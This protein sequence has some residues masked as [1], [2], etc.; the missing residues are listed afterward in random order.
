M[1]LE[2]VFLWFKE[3]VS[4]QFNNK[5]STIICE[6]RPFHWYHFRP[7][8]VSLDSTF[9]LLSNFKVKFLLLSH[10]FLGKKFLYYRSLAWICLNF[11][12]NIFLRGFLKFSLKIQLT[13]NIS[14]S[15]INQWALIMVEVIIPQRRKY[16]QKVQVSYKLR[17]APIG[18]INKKH[19]WETAHAPCHL[20]VR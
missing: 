16:F 8:L 1:P 17:F 11:D 6:K 18:C 14:K 2:E 7:L 9:K 12:N 20:I 19:V 4:F 10:L 13:I 3:S 5:M 15:D